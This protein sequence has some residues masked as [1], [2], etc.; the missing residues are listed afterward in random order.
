MWTIKLWDTI[1]FDTSVKTI[2]SLYMYI[3]DNNYNYDLIILC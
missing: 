1:I 2:Q 3:Q